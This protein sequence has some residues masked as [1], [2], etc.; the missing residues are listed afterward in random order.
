MAIDLSRYPPQEPLS[1]LG[2]AYAAECLRRSDGV[3]ARC[4]GYSAAYGD[5]PYQCLCVFPAQGVSHSVLLFFHGGGWTSGYQEWMHFMAPALTARGITLVT[6]GYRLAPQHVFPAS[7]DDAANAVIWVRHHIARHG[8]DPDRLFVGGHS[9]GGHLAALLAVG[10]GRRIHHHLPQSPLLGCLP[11]SGV[12]LFGEGS[13]LSQKPRFLGESPDSERLASPL[14]ALDGG[15]CP[16]W[17]L[18]YG[19]RDFGHLVAQAAEMEKA[20]VSHGVTV[21]RHV[22]LDCDH[23]GASLACG[24]QADEGWPA[25]AAE[26]MRQTGVRDQSKTSRST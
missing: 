12:Y 4:G 7:L 21:Q 20:L 13:G 25:V 19:E 5:D 9:A 15:I 6:A 10:K 11:V 2:A 8:G 3:L 24:E 17:L 22:L 26:W 1:P 18:A 14:Q 16:S 23:F